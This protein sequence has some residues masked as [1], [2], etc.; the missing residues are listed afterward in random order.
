MNYVYQIWYKSFQQF[1]KTTFKKYFS[2]FKHM[3]VGKDFHL[4]KKKTFKASNRR[5][6]MT[7]LFLDSGA[8][9]VKVFR[10]WQQ[11]R[12]ISTNIRFFD[13][14]TLN[15]KYVFKLPS[16][17]G[18]NYF[19]SNACCVKQNSLFIIKKIR[20]RAEPSTHFE[21]ESHSVP[22]FRLRNVS[23][24]DSMTPYLVIKTMLWRIHSKMFQMKHCKECE[25]K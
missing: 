5:C 14:T 16:W 7:F 25:K 18:V 4:K 17:N 6:F 3:R 15:M 12:T 13:P 11:T 1:S 24:R 2:I 23:S 21:N 19:F 22:F 20:F 9:D 8:E 10:E